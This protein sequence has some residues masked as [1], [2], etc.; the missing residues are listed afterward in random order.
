MRFQKV[1][2][3]RLDRAQYC[4]AE[5]IVKVYDQ[6]S[7]ARR[8]DRSPSLACRTSEGQYYLPRCTELEPQDDG[9]IR[10]LGP[11]GSGAGR[12]LAGL[13]FDQCW[14]GSGEGKHH[15]I[16]VKEFEYRAAIRQSQQS[17]VA[18]PSLSCDPVDDLALARSHHE[19]SVLETSELITNEFILA[20]V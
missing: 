1:L 12:A 16:T 4:P 5:E 19:S 2:D 14:P 18:N 17:T 6:V 3:E 15:R 11:V 10:S 8:D 7:W 13:M 9:A 20:E